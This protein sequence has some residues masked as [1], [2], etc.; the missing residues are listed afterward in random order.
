M[1]RHSSCLGT[2]QLVL[3]SR[4]RTD[5]RDDKAF[6]VGGHLELRVWRNLEQLED[7]LVDNNP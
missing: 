3:P 5:R 1:I 6:T 7:W 4:L 2:S